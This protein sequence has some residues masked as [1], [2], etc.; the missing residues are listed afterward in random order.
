M[1]TNRKSCS[2]WD[3]WER[4]RRCRVTGGI[5][6]TAAGQDL[7][8]WPVSGDAEPIRVVDRDGEEVNPRVSP[9]GRWVAYQSNQSGSAEV[10][11]ELFPQGGG[12]VPVS[13]GGGT[14][15][16]WRGDGRELYY[17]DPGGR[18]MAASLSGAEQPEVAS[19]QVLADAKIISTSPD[20]TKTQAARARALATR[21]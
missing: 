21:S 8:A 16:L 9:D 14:Q 4:R 15:P 12:R 20:V 1:G 7:W 3:G 11:I 18:L 6:S 19:T 2:T 5:S 13:A 17:V 10:Y